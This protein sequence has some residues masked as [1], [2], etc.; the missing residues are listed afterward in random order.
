MNEMEKFEL[1]L[2]EVEEL[3]P[4]ESLWYLAVG[5]SWGLLCA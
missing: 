4:V 5:S 1:E 3:E 2:E